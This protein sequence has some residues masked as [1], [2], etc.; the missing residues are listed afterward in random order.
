MQRIEE[1][2][3]SNWIL[4]DNL[5]AFLLAISALAEYSFD[6]GDEAAIEF[7]IVD[8]D[9]EKDRWFDYLLQGRTSIG[10]A[11]AEDPG[12]NVIFFRVEADPDVEAKV[13]AVISLFQE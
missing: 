4:R 8:T 7:G 10:L 5:D 11:L 2:M 12:S 3:V 1:V 9:V 6:D 13:D